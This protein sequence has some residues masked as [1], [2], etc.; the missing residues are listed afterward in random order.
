MEKIKKELKKLV[1]VARPVS[2]KRILLADDSK[3]IRE[4]ASDFLEFIGYELAHAVNGIEALSGF[5]ASSFDLVL[6]DIEM[7]T[8]DELSLAGHVKEKSPGT[9]SDFDNGI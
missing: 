9:P 6:T 5:L 4:V 1:P 7:P 2:S 3:S 8:M